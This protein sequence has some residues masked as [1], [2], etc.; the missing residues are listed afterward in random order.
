MSRRPNSELPGPVQQLLAALEDP[1]V[2]DTKFQALTNI[3][4]AAA[5]VGTPTGVPPQLLLEMAR[6]LNSGEPIVLATAFRIAREQPGITS[7]QSESAGTWIGVRR[8]PV[9]SPTP[10]PRHVR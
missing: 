7:R 10:Q 9:G 2:D 4:L 8:R 3:F 6:T 1:P 5:T